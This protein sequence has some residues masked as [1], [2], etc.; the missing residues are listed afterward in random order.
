MLT[1]GEGELNRRE[2][3]VDLILFYFCCNFVN[4]DCISQV[5][6]VVVVVV[7]VEGRCFSV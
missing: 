3:A 5:V 1:S 6:V 4:V 2:V 7:V